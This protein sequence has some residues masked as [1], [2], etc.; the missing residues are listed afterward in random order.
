MMLKTDEKMGPISSCA[1][2]TNR[3]HLRYFIT[4]TLKMAGAGRNI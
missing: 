3:A 1:A 4:P 2:A